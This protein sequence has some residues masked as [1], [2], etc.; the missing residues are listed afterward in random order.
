MLLD[1]PLVGEQVEV[2]TDRGG[3]QS[4]AR[5]ESGSSERAI[6]R[7]CLPNP[8][9]GACLKNVRRGGGPL[10]TVRNGMVSDK[11]KYIVT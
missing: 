7:D 10:C 5:G 1:G 11:H 6:L 4:Q 3:R 8:V 9:P 2:A